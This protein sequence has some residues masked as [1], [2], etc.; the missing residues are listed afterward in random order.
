MAALLTN[1]TSNTTGT[2]TATTA[3]NV[4]IE[5][6]N[7]SVL[8]GA[9]VHIQASSA[10]TA[11]KYS[12]TARPAIFKSAGWVQLQLPIGTFVRAV[13]NK[14]GAATNVSVNLLE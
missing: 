13:L 6:P 8:D 7:D 14:A 4:W 2:G 3:Q 1:A 11:G 12:P 10:D 9:E 5:V